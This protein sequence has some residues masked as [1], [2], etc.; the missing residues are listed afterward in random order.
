MS[1]GD[2]VGRPTEE[3]VVEAIKRAIEWFDFD[4]PEPVNLALEAESLSL[5]RVVLANLQAKGF[6]V[7]ARAPELEY[8]P[9]DKSHRPG[10]P[11][12]PA[13]H[14]EYTKDLTE[15]IDL[16][17]DAIDREYG[18]GE[19]TAQVLAAARSW[20][21]L[22]DSPTHW[23]CET[24]DAQGF[25]LPEPFEPS[26]FGNSPGDSTDNP[27]QLIRVALVELEEW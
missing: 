9:A 3:R 14:G 8:S 5:A 4:A 25:K 11:E 23:W 24:H 15:A 21:T 1:E 16:W 12:R 22:R 18:H 19:I 17:D 10:P 7:V 26:C 2:T 13:T 6:E 20:D 27:C